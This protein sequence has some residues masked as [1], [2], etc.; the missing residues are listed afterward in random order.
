MARAAGALLYIGVHGSANGGP[1]PPTGL[2]ACSPRRDIGLSRGA[3]HAPC[4]RR[5]RASPP[6]APRGRASAQ[7]RAGANVDPDLHGLPSAP[8]GSRGF[9]PSPRP[10]GTTGS[11]G[12]GPHLPQEWA[13]AATGSRGA[14]PAGGVAAHHPS[15]N[16]GEQRPIRTTA[17]PLRVG[18]GWEARAQRLRSS[19]PRLGRWEDGCAAWV[20]RWPIRPSPTAESGAAPLRPQRIRA[21]VI[22]RRTA[23]TGAAEATPVL[24]W[25]Q[26]RWRRWSAYRDKDPSIA[27]TFWRYLR[28]ERGRD[29]VSA[30]LSAGQT[31]DDIRGS[32]RMR[33][34]FDRVVAESAQRRQPKPGC[35]VADRVSGG[36]QGSLR[37]CGCA[38]AL[39]TRSEAYP[40]LASHRRRLHRS[41]L[42]ACATWFVDPPYRGGKRRT[43]PLRLWRHRLR[44][45]AQWCR[46]SRQG[47]VAV[48]ENKGACWLPFVD[49]GLATATS[50]GAPAS[51]QPKSCGRKAG[52]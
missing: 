20:G 47:Q 17:G 38:S 37:V 48:C 21:L 10:T 26:R 23:A 30:R 34:R 27:E 52:R 14:L 35:E 43:I 9:V 15:A 44:H 25:P 28:G 7:G 45:L 29:P 24:P 46:R 2:V 6:R 18:G 36:R 8:L 31:V 40:S 12:P 42:T 19:G 13:P 50:S 3:L 22:D 49:V 1:G 39:L 16:E 11:A 32:L 41:A 4:S 33:E 51:A 5:R